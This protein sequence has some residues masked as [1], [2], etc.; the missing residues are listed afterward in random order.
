MAAPIVAAEHDQPHTFTLPLSINNFFTGEFR[1]RL[2]NWRSWQHS[3]QALLAFGK[4]GDSMRALRNRIVERARS[5]DPF[6]FIIFFS[7]FGLL[8]CLLLGFDLA[9][10]ALFR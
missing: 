4:I 5:I 8:I 1:G 2:N 6:V 7:G 10:S 3:S 9:L